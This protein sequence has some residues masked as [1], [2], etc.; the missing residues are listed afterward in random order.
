[1]SK[2]NIWG[3]QEKQV[4]KIFLRS[5]DS[6]IAVASFVAIEGQFAVV[7]RVLAGK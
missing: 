4:F 1:V 5:F 6:L 7:E 3:I 2:W